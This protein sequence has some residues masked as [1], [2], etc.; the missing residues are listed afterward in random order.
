MIRALIVDDEQHAREELQVLLEA[1]DAFEIVGSC[2]NALEAIRVINRDQPQV[3][4]LDIDMP[5]LSGFELLSMLEKE[6][7]PQVVFVTAYDEFALKAFEE[8]AVDYLLK[9]VDPERLNKTVEKLQQVG[10]STLPAHYRTAE[11]K[12]IPCIGASRVKLINPG[13]VEFVRSDVSGIHLI[14]DDGEFFTE[15]TLKTLEQRTNLVRC[16]KQYLVNPEKIDEILL[17]EGGLAE[18]HTGSGRQLPV[19]RRYMKLLKETFE[20]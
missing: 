14:T 13:S 3:I 16:H 20:L 1:T 15:L 8:Q 18:I 7:M 9:P 12:R 5:V 17:L 19:S 4:F 11:L 10:A 6:Q 2:S